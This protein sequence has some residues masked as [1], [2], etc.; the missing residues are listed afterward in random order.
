M[1]D[2]RR[3]YERRSD[4]QRRVVEW[5]CVNPIGSTPDEVANVVEISPSVAGRILKRLATK[6]LVRRDEL[7]RWAAAE[8]LL[9]V[10]R[11]VRLG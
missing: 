5:L 4:T 2:D 6:W 3:D 9:H 1:G 7:S 11:L 10:P 8:L